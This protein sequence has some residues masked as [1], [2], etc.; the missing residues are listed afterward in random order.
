M[1][2]TDV[3]AGVAERPQAPKATARRPARPKPPLSR[4]VVETRVLG[5]LK[6]ITIAFFLIATLFPF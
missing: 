6:W 5:V 4:E 3:D 2:R 1:S